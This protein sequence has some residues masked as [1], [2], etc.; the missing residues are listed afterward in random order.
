MRTIQHYLPNPRHTE[1]NRIFVKAKPD[2]AWQTARHFDAADIPWVRLLF[3]IRAIPDLLKGKKRSEEDRSV[4][5]DQVARQGTGFMILE[6]KPGREVV[7]GSVGQFWHLNIPF[8]SVSP[9]DFHAFNEPGWGKLAW[10]ISVEPFGEGS[11]I[12]LELRTTATDD[13]SWGNLNRYYAVIGLGSKPIRSAAMAHLQAEL[14]KMKLPD[15]D[16]ISLPGDERI[17]EAKH[18]MTHSVDIEA[19]PAIVWR[20]LMQLGC[21]RAGWYSLD[22]LDNGG[23]PSI[24][25]LVEGWETR[26]VGDRLAA[27]PEQDGFFDVFAVEKERHFVVGNEFD[28][29]IAG[30]GSLKMSWAFVLQPIGDDATRLITRVRGVVAPKWADWLMGHLVYPPIHAIMQITELKNIKRLAERDAWMR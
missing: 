30:S 14:G 6:E 22:I 29:T 24:D 2:V 19:P 16:E 21:D 9:A 28:K 4:G 12:S 25:H 26:E 18:Q 13:E 23:K 3:D 10:A 17:P 1:I 7:I 15:E 20:Y 11:T 27:T 8:A 5:V